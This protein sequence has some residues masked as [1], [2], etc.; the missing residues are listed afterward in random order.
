MKTVMAKMIPLQDEI[1]QKVDTELFDHEITNIKILL[2]DNTGTQIDTTK[3]FGTKVDN[4]GLERQI[5]ELQNHVDRL[6]QT[7][8]AALNNAKKLDKLDP[9]V[10]E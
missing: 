2:T 4:S 1:R 5:K 3:F 7:E 9:L 6:N 10:L 8:T